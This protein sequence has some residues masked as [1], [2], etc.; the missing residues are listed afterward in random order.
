MLYA[1]TPDRRH[2]L[3]RGAPLNRAISIKAPPLYYL[4][5]T[6]GSSQELPDAISASREVDF[7]VF[8]DKNQKIAAR[9]P[10]A[11]ITIM[12]AGDPLVSP[13]GSAPDRL[14]LLRRET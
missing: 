3:T 8:R 14:D 9:F 2:F 1:Y 10:V 12:R 4:L 5:K 13:E 6:E 11:P 7:L